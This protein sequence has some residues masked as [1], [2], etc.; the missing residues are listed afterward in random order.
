[1]NKK[2]II[3]TRVSTDEQAKNGGSLSDQEEKLRKYC[4]NNQIEIVAHFQDDFSAKTF[5][6]P[7]FNKLLTF[8][9]KYKNDVDWLLVSR[10][11]RFSRNIRESYNMIDTLEGIGPR[12]QAIEAP[13]DMDIPEQRILLAIYLVAPEVENTRRG[14][15]V[16]IGQRKAIKDGRW[17]RR[18]P[19][20]YRNS[21]DE[22]NRP[23][24]VP[25]E[26]TAPLVQ[27][28]FK[29]FS[30][31][32][33]TQE[34]LRLKFNKKGLKLTKSNL[35]LLLRNKFYVGQLHLPATKVEP[36]LFVNGIH[37]PLISTLVFN[38]V[39]SILT[40]RNTRRN[41]PPRKQRKP[42]LVLRGNILCPKCNEK[43][44]GSRSKGN[45]GYY[46]YYHCNHCR[47]VRF[48]ANEAN[49]QFQELLNQLRPKPE[50][51]QL[52]FAMVNKQK[53]ITQKSSQND[54]K[55]LQAQ[56]DQ[57][58]KRK[59]VLTDR[60]LDEV[61]SNEDF[62]ELNNQLKSQLAE[63]NQELEKLKQ[64]VNSIN[65]D[66]VKGLKQTFNLK[67]IYEKSDL[68]GKQQIIGSIFPR[69]FYFE[70]SK[71]R[72]DKINEV[73]GWIM[74]NNRALAEIK[75]GQP[76]KNTKLSSLVGPPGLEPGTN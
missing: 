12:I 11:D 7:E 48:R 51:Q 22:N 25:N 67:D 29:E 44:T 13:L 19:L 47:E 31:G 35:S 26:Q 52:F 70:D 40:G 50:I 1:M 2:A 17:P 72:T 45:G 65:T 10:W 74:Q 15:N 53:R 60:F 28:V 36:E 18:A 8:L 75:K 38:K 49:N 58:S 71:V 55:K 14:M 37:E 6:R 56:F 30:C 39:H 46:Y 20:G 69:K 24:V 73:I 23:T 63:T 57:L 4:D 27:K 62:S 3:Y 66:F 9:K 42:E 43:L 68:E 59:S 61:I 54:I 64:S 76:S 5:N 32:N 33:I 21:R 16:S 34:E 41:T